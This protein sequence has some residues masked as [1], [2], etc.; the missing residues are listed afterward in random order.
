MVVVLV[1]G[2]EAGLREVGMKTFV[3]ETDGPKFPQ[4]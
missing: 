3:E 4:T 1:K 2:V